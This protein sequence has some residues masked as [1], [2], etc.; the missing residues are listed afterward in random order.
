MN[1]FLR[2]LKR[3]LFQFLLLLGCFFISRC[4]FTLMQLKYF[5]GITFTAFLSCAFSGI[6]FDLS[7]LFILNGLYVLLLLLPHYKKDKSLWERML[8][9]L[10]LSV[11]VLAFLFEI[12]DW[13]YFP[14]NHKRATADVLNLILRKGDFLV[15]LPRFFIEY[16]YVPLS[17]IAFIYLFAKA[18]NA[19][20]KASPIANKQKIKIIPH[21]LRIVLVAG[22]G[23]LSIRGGLQLIPMGIRDA[24][25]KNDS[26]YSAIVL[27]TPF[28]IINT[29][30]NDELKEE[31]YFDD[32]TLKSLIN[33][34]KQYS[35]KPFTAKNVVVIILES[36]SKEFTGIG[37]LESYTPFLDSL[38]QHSLACTNA[39]ANGLRSA[40]GIPAIL[41]GIPAMQEEPFTT[42]PY[43][44]NHITAIPFLLT[45]KGYSSAFYHGGNNGTMSFDL[46]AANAGFQHYKGRDEYNNEK[47]Y[48]GNWGIWDEPFLQ[49]AAKDIGKTLKQPFIASI[50][51]LS[52]H[53]PYG[54]PPQ[55]KNQFPK[56]TLEIHETIGYTDFAL[57]AFFAT[58]QQQSWYNN[59]LFIIVPDHCS[60]LSG[61]P[62][63]NFHQG[64][65][66]I[67]IIYFAPGDST[68]KGT[69]ELLT[70]QVDI[71]PSLM[72]YL[73]FSEAFFSFGKSIFSNERF[74]SVIQSSNNHL[75]FTMDNYVLHAINMQ[76]DALY[77]W[78]KDPL[79][80]ENLVTQKQL[81]S[82]QYMNR[83]KAFRQAYTK[84][85]I[86]N[87]MTVK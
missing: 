63:Y 20:A 4:V 9:V 66:A 59:T 52:S 34:R 16:W 10:F 51:T 42:S 86:H 44:A 46:F 71:L 12:S 21:F 28:S 37:G 60:P 78:K 40:D 30:T 3:L 33:T 7:A 82:Q 58:A 64:K 43:G 65:Y 22:I 76:A 81:L 73:G 1:D 32:K 72:D 41:A 25:A 79:E 49:Y 24:V 54:I 39:F 56:G 14:Y 61:D 36:F 5:D 8:Q 48:D 11:N 15:L 84:A 57:R 75:Y 85:M 27:N 53:F 47:D 67:P 17:A 70:G 19:I 26:R 50:F 77:D 29:F 2:P 62:Y 31:V 69:N 23:I 87:E 74:R 45:K 55:H 18:N 38:M 13:A 35:G 68:L 80:S 83:L 6:R